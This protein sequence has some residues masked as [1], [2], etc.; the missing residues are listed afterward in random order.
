MCMASSEA[1]VQK[2]EQEWREQL[3]PEQ[4]EVLRQGR[5]RA[6]VHRRVRLQ[7]GVRRL[8]LRGLR[9]DA[10]QGRHE[11]RLGHRLAE[12]HRAR[13]R[14]GGRAAPRQQPVHAPHGG[15][16]PHLRRAPRPRLRRRP[17]ADRP[18]LLHQLGSPSSSCPEEGAEQREAAADADARRREL[19]ARSPVASL[20]AMIMYEQS[21]R[22]SRAAAL[23][24]AREDG[25]DRRCS[26]R[27]DAR[28]DRP[29][30]LRAHERRARA[31]AT[32]SRSRSR[33]RS[34]APT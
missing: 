14:R 3:T 24:P 18:A 11:V 20:R 7:Q 8:P 23:G 9:R 16:L 13:R 33:A 15:P 34:A 12:L 21:R 30:R 4:Y 29:R 22:L 26:W 10:V 5:H 19:P 1:K 2:S 25:G 28:A 17:R 6:A 31:C 32:A 27:R